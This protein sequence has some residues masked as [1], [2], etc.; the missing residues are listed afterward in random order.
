MG[1]S[2]QKYAAMHINF[3][4][5][6]SRTEHA[7]QEEKTRRRRGEESGDIEKR[8]VKRVDRG[9]GTKAAATVCLSSSSSDMEKGCKTSYVKTESVKTTSY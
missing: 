4:N 8:P 9:G 2:Y 3:R 5:Q 1:S 6:I 7:R